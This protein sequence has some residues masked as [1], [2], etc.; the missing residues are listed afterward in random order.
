[1]E[2]WLEIRHRVLREGVSKR[3]ILRETRMHWKTL[4]RIL[5]HPAPPPFEF[6]PRPKLKIGPYLDRIVEFLEADKPPTPRKQRHTAKRIFERLQ[7]EGYPGG[8]TA[9]K[10]AVRELKQQRQAVYMPL[11]HRPGEAQV[12]FGEAVVKVGG[13]LQKVHFFVMALPYSDAF[14]VVAYERECTETFQDGH[15]RAF[16]FFGGVPRRITYD[17]ARTSVSKILGAHKRKRTDGFL[18]LQSHYLFEDHFCCVRR[19][20]E[21]GVVEGMVKYLRQ[22]F[23]VPTP[24]VLDLEELNAYLTQRC[25]EDLHRKVRGQTALKCELLQ[26]EQASFWELPPTPFDACRKWS[27]TSNSLS[28]VRFDDNDYSVPVSYAHRP[29]LVK[30]YVDV[31]RIYK[32]DKQVAEHR[33]KWNK[34]QVVF[35]PVHY[36]AL[37][38]DKPGA[39]DFG[40]PFADWKLPSCFARLRR[41]QEREWDGEGTKEFI[42]VLRLLEKHRLPRLTRA[43]EHALRIHAFTCDAIALFLYPDEPW[44]PA[45]FRLDGREHLQ[46]I[47]VAEPDLTVYKRLHKGVLS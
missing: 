22:N 36:L 28:L 47:V 38:E 17:N 12:D 33:R 5:K 29:V 18:Q 20:N 13:V 26:E 42:Q 34:E 39:F 3:Q 21:K 44:Q 16:E 30:G 15:V 11:T 35:E 37:L 8:Y 19:A 2:K 45:T 46:G 1:M 7:A 40:R 10:D 14:F 4:E 25:R 31:V 24:D 32:E 6:G 27:T 23:F 9:V 43:V 41:C